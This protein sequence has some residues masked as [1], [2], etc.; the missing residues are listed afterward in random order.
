MVQGFAED[1]AIVSPKS[2]KHTA[3]LA[4]S[5]RRAVKTP[6][7]ASAGQAVEPVTMDGWK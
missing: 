1:E 7:L 2:V 3:T 6:V 5:A 4:S